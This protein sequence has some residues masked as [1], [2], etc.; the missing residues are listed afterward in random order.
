MPNSLNIPLKK[1]N[2]NK[3]NQKTQIKSHCTKSNS[4][5]VYS[6][7]IITEI[8]TIQQQQ[9]KNNKTQRK[10]DKKLPAK[11][12]NGPSDHLM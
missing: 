8:K 10:A 1:C 9:N 12:Y 2:Q 11:K 5:T 4:L 7:R 3:I 6:A